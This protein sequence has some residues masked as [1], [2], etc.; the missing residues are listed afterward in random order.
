MCVL[1]AVALVH[2]EILPLV[3]AQLGAVDDGHLVGR[4]HHGLHFDASPDLVPLP[5][6]FTQVGPC[7]FVPVV[8]DHWNLVG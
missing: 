5:D 2:D 3:V 6:A 7:V 1:D 8:Q 4:D